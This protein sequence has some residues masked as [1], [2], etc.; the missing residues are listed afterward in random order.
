MRIFFSS[1]YY[2]LKECFNNQIT[3]TGKIPFVGECHFNLVQVIKKKHSFRITTTGFLMS[4]TNDLD[5]MNK[6]SE[7]FM[8][9]VVELWVTFNPC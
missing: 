7:C 1:F 9:L 6:T 5:Y 8:H 2:S 3:G 4:R